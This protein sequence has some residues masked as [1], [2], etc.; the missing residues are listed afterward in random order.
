MK[1]EST[2]SVAAEILEIEEVLD[3]ETGEFVQ[4]KEKI[5]GDYEKALQLRMSDD[6]DA[7]Q[8]LIEIGDVQLLLSDA[9]LK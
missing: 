4:A 9:P 1:R 3:L 2:C 7:A 6:D 5:G 8:S